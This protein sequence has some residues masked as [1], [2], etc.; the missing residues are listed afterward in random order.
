MFEVNATVKP[1]VDPALVD[2]RLDEIMADYLANG[3]TEDEVAAPRPAKSPAACAGWS[4]SAASAA[5]R[6]R[7][8]RARCS[9]AT[10]NIH[11][12]ARRL[13]R[14]H[15]GRD[16]GGD[17]AMADPPGVQGH[18]RAGRAPALRRGQGHQGARKV[19][20]IPPQASQARRPAG[21]PVR[22]RSTSPTSQHADAVERR[23][24][25]IM[26]SAPRCR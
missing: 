20:D 11:K 3:P 16:Q 9:P 26:R 7:W 5:R 15:P 21:R 24:R 6:S 14:G 17:A 1:G 2:K 25:S 4:R 10:A 13:C 18:A 8:P 12:H 22:R 23:R 19:V